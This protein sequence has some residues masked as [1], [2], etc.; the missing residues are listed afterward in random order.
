MIVQHRAPDEKAPFEENDESN[1]ALE[2]C[3]QDILRA[4]DQRDAKHL[5]LA[6][7]AAYEVCESY[8]DDSQDSKE[9]N[10]YDSL[11]E[12]AAKDAAE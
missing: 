2:A 1:S 10:D 12:K 6:L 3:A 8:D 4:I 9:A 11:N 7:Q 5:A